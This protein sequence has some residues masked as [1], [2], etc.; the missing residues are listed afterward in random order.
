MEEQVYLSEKPITKLSVNGSNMLTYDY[1]DDTISKINSED[2]QV[3]QMEWTD[4]A[5]VFA[6]RASPDFDDEKYPYF[7]ALSNK[8]I[9][10]IDI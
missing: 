4:N 8:A 3:E 7:Y 6:L 1:S 10:V 5:A 9:V 2:G